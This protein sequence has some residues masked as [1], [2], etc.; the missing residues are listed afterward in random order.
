MKTSDFDFE[1][2]ESFIAQDPVTPRDHS[3]LLVYDTAKDEVSHRLFYEIEDYL[4][5]NDVL[6]LNNSKVIPARI[7]F[8]HDGKECEIFLLKRLGEWKFQVMVRPGKYFEVGMQ[9]DISENLSLF[10]EEV[11]EDGSRIVDLFSFVDHLVLEEELEKIGRCPLPPYIKNS[12]ATFDQYQTVYAKDKGSVA[13][14]TAGLHFTRELLE[15]LSE[16]G[17]AR[18]EAILHVGRGTFLPVKEEEI[19]NHLMHQE[20]LEMPRNTAFSLNEAREKGKRFI[21]VGTTSVRI[22]ESCFDENAGFLPKIGETDIFI[23]PGYK[24]KAVDA[25]L[26]NFHL[27]KSTLL[28]LVSSF[29]ESKGVKE[30]VKKLLELYEVAKKENYRFYSFGDAMFII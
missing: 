23:Y 22:L 28:M 12:K 30:P 8:E 25:L 3:K 27:P 10:V 16:K 26:T 1:L 2:P 29:L 13:A 20:Y 17:V 11:L 21:A 24:W 18:E 19:E 6:V 14:P 7:I 9:L 4:D 15:R 5:E